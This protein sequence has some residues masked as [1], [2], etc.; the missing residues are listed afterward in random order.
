MADFRFGHRIE[1]LRRQIGEG[2]TPVEALLVTDM[3]NVRYLT[4]FTGSSGAAIFTGDKALFL[5][6]GR[7]Q[8]QSAQEVTGFERI[9][10]PQG[11]RLEARAAEVLN[12]AG[13][14]KVGFEGGHMNYNAYTGL[15]GKL[16]ETIELIPR[17]DVV[18]GLRMIKDSTELA[19]IRDAVESA[20]ACFDF[21]R[22]TVKVGMTEKELAWEIEVFLR[23]REGA[24]RLG[25]DSI[26]GCGPNSAMIHGRPTHRKIGESGGPE[27]LLCDYGCEKDGYNSDITR[28]F[29]IGGEPTDKHLKLYEAV[30]VAQ[31]AALDAIKPG[32]IGKEIQQVAMDSLTASG[33]GEYFVH[34]LGH[35]LGRLVHDHPA[36]S[37]VSEIVLRE[38]MVLTVE[39]GAYIESFGGVRIEDDI[40]VTENGCE[41]LTKSTKELV[42]LP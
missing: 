3:E 16:A 17:D 34:G 38:G 21:I 12:E 6:D 33:Y 31:Q 9:I 32:K 7:Y 11:T 22:E 41:I 37:A 42:V 18:M 19:A 30:K 1:G 2:E 20:D 26:I 5:T 40:L 13:V 15:R 4:G 27:L 8:L 39:P 14:G 24:A 36:M 10:V 35:G 29:V 28:T 23:K 25:F